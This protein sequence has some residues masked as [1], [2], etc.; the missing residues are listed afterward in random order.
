MQVLSK[1]IILKYVELKIRISGEATQIVGVKLF[2]EKDLQKFQEY[3]KA[4][5]YAYIH[6]GG[7]RFGLVPSFRNGI[8]APILEKQFDSRHLDYE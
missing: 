5:K 4:K 8:N 1:K 7:I 3:V 6:F 2:Q